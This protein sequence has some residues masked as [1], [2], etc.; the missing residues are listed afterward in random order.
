M[1]RQQAWASKKERRK[2]AAQQEAM[3]EALQECLATPGVNARSRE[4]AAQ[5][6]W[7]VNPYKTPIDCS[8]ARA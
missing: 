5:I 8:R 4:L 6:G 1:R 3:D 2:Q 7:Q